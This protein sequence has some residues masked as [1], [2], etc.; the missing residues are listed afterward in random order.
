MN[1]RTYVLTHGGGHGGWCYQRVAPLLGAAGHDV[2]AP[3][4]TGLAD[5]AADRVGHIV[6]L[7]AAT[8]ANGDRLRRTRT[9]SPRRSA[10]RYGP[11]TASSSSCSPRLGSHASSAITEP[12]DVAWLVERLTPHPWKSLVQPLRL[13][14]EAALRAIPQTH[15]VC[16]A[17][18]PI[19]DVE[20][21]RKW[22]TV[23]C[24][25]S[26]RVTTS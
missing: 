19:R 15:I 10:V 21:I 24:G 13:T 3:S 25:T 7:D 4:L 16:T 9:H 5:R 26:T 11:S 1:K 2:Y 17:S 12:D 14:N 18:L 23:D 6:Y 22:P 8:P 20:H